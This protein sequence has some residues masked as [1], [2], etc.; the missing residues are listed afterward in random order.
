[1]VAGLAKAEPVD[2]W[3][4]QDVAERATPVVDL[5]MNPARPKV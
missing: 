3:E 4:I 2:L 5:S 1:M